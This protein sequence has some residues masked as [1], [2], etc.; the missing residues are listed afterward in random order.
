M[1]QYHSGLYYQENSNSNC[2]Q[3]DG[4][5]PGVCPDA[6]LKRHDTRPAFKVMMETCDGVMDLTDETLVVEVSLWSKA[7][8]K[9]TIA[10]D[11]TYFQVADNIGFEQILVGDIIVLD[12]VRLPEHMLVTGFDEANH[13]VQVQRAYNGTTASVWKKGTP[14]RIF[15]EMGA[16]ASIESVLGDV[17]DETGTTQTD[18]LLETYLVYEWEAKDTC[19]PG[20]YWLEFKLLKMT[21]EEE[22]LHALSHDEISNIS[23]T[24]EGLTYAD[25]GCVLG[26]GVEWVRRFPSEG[27]GFLIKITNSPTAEI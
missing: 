6:V 4:C 10:A 5:P 16:S 26:D 7:K 18:Q 22:D 9:R 1:L 12:R 27:E 19:T 25:Y 2:L 11:D 24:G 13:L 17:V 8:L 3:K 14:M 20:C 23:F 21:E 15:R